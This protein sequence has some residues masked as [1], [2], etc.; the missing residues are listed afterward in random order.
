MCIAHRNGGAH[1]WADTNTSTSLFASWRLTPPHRS[2]PVVSSTLCN[3]SSIKT[4]ELEA[5]EARFKNDEVGAPAYSP[6]VLLKIVLLAYSKGIVRSR[7]IEALCRD[8]V[9]FI[10]ISGDSQPHFTTIAKFVS[11]QRERHRRAVRPGAGDLRSGRADRARDVRHRR[12]EAAQ[13]R[14]QGQ[15]RHARADFEREAA[16]M[17]AAVSKMLERH[18]S[19]RCAGERRA[20]RGASAWR[21]ASS[22]S[23]RSRA[24]PRVAERAPARSH[25]AQRRRAPEQPHRQRVGQDGHRQGR[26]PGLHRGGRGRRASTRSSS[27]RKP[28]AWARSRSCWCPVVDALAIPL[29]APTPWS[30]PTR[31]TA[32]RHNLKASSSAASRPTS[33]T[34]TGASATSASPDSSRTGTSPIR[35]GTRPRKPDKPKLFGPQTSA[36]RRPVALHLPGGQAALPQRPASRPER[37][38]GG[39]LHRQPSATAV[40]CPLRA[41]CLRKPDTHAGAASG[42]LHRSHARQARAGDS[43]A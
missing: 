40:A 13:Q 10:A 11:S 42:D 20:E 9:L 16:K 34:P 31:A 43:S 5:F 23:A 19:R 8:N 1:R 33:R 24:D 29:R 4:I 18:R 25:R 30:P 22:G 21:A 26:D 12:G 15:E 36:R 2:S 37:L 17:E 38:P 28:T 39:A 14:L 32:A 41:Q 7:D 6:A 35:C 3:C 27:R